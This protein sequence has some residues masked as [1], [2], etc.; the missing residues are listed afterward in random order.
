[1]YEDVRGRKGRVLT[2]SQL[3]ERQ[4]R[5]SSEARRKGRGMG[6]TMYHGRL[7]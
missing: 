7:G 3:Y 6:E 2:E 4:S 1:M 5:M